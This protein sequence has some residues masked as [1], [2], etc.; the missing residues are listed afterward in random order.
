[1]KDIP[2]FCPICRNTKLISPYENVNYK[3][4]CP[5]CD[6][7]DEKLL[8]R[9]NIISGVKDILNKILISLLNGED[10][11]KIANKIESSIKFIEE[12]K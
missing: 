11:K 1:M 4:R 3:I 12:L 6:E 7:V 9:K 10:N 2:Y 5:F 8:F